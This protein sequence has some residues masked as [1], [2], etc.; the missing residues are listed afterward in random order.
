MK[1]NTKGSALLVTII[2]GT[3]L[4]IA[5]TGILT[6][7]LNEY[8]GSL[9]SYLD[10][11]AFHIAES[12]I[13][14]AAAAITNNDFSNA[15]DVIPSSV[16]NESGIWYKGMRN[17]VVVYYRGFFPMVDLGNGRSGMCS[18]MCYPTT[19]TTYTIYTLGTATN[20]TN[21]TSQRAIKVE[22]KANQNT[23]SGNGAAIVAKR[24]LS[25]G[26]G[27]DE[28]PFDVTRE[29]YIRVA[30]YDSNKGAPNMVVDMKTGAITG[31]NYDDDT[32][33]GVK[34][35]TG[36]ANIYSAIVYGNIVTGGDRSSLILQN[37]TKYGTKQCTSGNPYA[38]TLVDIDSAAAYY[39]NNTANIGYTGFNISDTGGVGDNISTNFKFNDSDFNIDG[40][41]TDGS[42]NT[43][44]LIQTRLTYDKD[45]TKLVDSSN[46]NLNKNKVYIGPSNYTSGSGTKSYTVVDNVNDMEEIVIRGQ[47]VLIVGNNMNNANL[48]LS[49]VDD[50]ST[51]TLV[52]GNTSTSN[53]TYTLMTQNELN[54]IAP[55]DNMQG[56]NQN[57][58]NADYIP[59]RFKIES[60]GT[61][62]VW[63]RVGN[64]SR[65][66][67]VIKVPN[68]K[69]YIDCQSASRRNQF[70]GQLIADDVT[71]L[72][73]CCL[74]FFYD[75]QLGKSKDTKSKL[76]LTS[77]KQILP[78]TYVNQL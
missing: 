2:I 6:L 19:S 8:R 54:N 7:S 3:V 53:G 10:T 66:S 25:I 43:D 73:N 59:S 33:I 67:A 40:F 69:A 5:V 50:Q 26:S 22:F 65:A 9:K 17:G 24:S 45:G 29:S 23:G 39:K 13:D 4:L 21:I 48:K 14:R 49:F 34:D 36:T 60:A 31:S 47:A 38:C 15:V 63:F 61:P 20:G 74:D 62:T 16:S 57:I 76:S 27:S 35:S 75:V 58:Q 28:N 51:L 68:G 52:L 11:A 32:S 1:S 42:Y 71:I 70:R 44:G 12:G 18:V 64:K 56:V 78:S 41:N 30:S 37:N 77:W 72:G 46:A 55:D